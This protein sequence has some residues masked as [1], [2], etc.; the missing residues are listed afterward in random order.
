MSSTAWE[1]LRL[2][3]TSEIARNKN[4]FIPPAAVM[5]TA[6]RP[7]NLSRPILELSYTPDDDTQQ[8]YVYLHFAEVEDVNVNRSFS[9]WLN[10][11]L[12]YDQYLVLQGTRPLTVYSFYGVSGTSLD[13]SFYPANDSTLPPILNAIEFYLLKKFLES[14]TEQNDGE[15]IDL[16]ISLCFSTKYSSIIQT[17]I[18]FLF[19]RS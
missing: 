5:R 17:L 4:Y 7:K 6:I 16:H 9:I 18:M 1:S 19:G 13:F 12:F 15:F 2:R 8:I 3:N 11:G 14:P 10:G